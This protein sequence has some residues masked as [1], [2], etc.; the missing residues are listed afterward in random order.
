MKVF[1]LCSFNLKTKVFLYTESCRGFSTADPMGDCD[2][3]FQ[4]V[5]LNLNDTWHFVYIESQD[6]IWSIYA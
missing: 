6:S 5:R 1:Q 2:Y 3:S 4:E